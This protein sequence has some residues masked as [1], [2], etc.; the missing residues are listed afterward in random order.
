VQL[1]SGGT[2]KGSGTVSAISIASGGTLAPG[3]SP[4]TL[5]ASSAT[6]NGGGTYA[7]EINNFLGSAGSNWDFLNVTG[8]LAI[9]ASSGN[10]FVIDVISLLASSNTSGAASN[11]DA[12]SNYTFAIAT[13]AG[14][15]TGFDAS[16]FDIRTSQFSNLMNPAGTSAGGSWNITQNGSSINL[17][18]A[19]ATAI[20]E[21]NSAALTLIGLGVLALRRRHV[22]QCRAL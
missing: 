19:A 11:F 2:L 6:W 18:Y 16:S 14:G 7:W 20:P 12:F 17:N 21:P 9:N 3:N 22:S 15:V 1:N 8:A 5:T 10:K 13:A 4:G